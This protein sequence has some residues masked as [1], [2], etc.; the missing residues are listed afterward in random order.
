MN[1]KIQY[2]AVKDQTQAYL[3]DMLDEQKQVRGSSAFTRYLDVMSHF[4]RY[5]HSNLMLIAMQCPDARKVAG[6]RTWNKLKRKVKKG[7]QA[8]KIWAPIKTRR[9]K[10]RQESLPDTENSNLSDAQRMA[11]D[12]QDDAGKSKSGM[13]FRLVSVFDLSQTE[14]EPLADEFFAIP[15]REDAAVARSE[16][17]IQALSEGIKEQGYSVVFKS[18]DEDCYGLANFTQKTVILNEQ[19]DPVTQAGTLAHEWAHVLLHSPGESGHRLPDKM[20]ETEAESVA[21]VVMRHAGLP[22][23][24]PSYLAVE[25][26]NESE[27]TLEK[28]TVATLDRVRGAVSTQLDALTP[29]LQ[30]AVL[31][32]NQSSQSPTAES[33]MI[34]S[35]PPEPPEVQ[36][37]EPQPQNMEWQ[38]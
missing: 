2:E 11:Q 31:E 16:L 17:V 28:L 25:L 15:E 9:K 23:E 34:S 7:E 4:H 20:Q 22:S 6:L 26:Q 1:A 19:H 12:A 37:P 24:A 14:G 35:E 36:I 33:E 10:Q 30:A 18:M 38:I 8:I 21:Y 5:S 27:D 32:D 29:V 13:R 3:A